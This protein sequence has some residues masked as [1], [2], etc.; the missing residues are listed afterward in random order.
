MTST[1]EINRSIDLM[2]I[3]FGLETSTERKARIDRELSAA[4]VQMLPSPYGVS[5]RI[6]GREAFINKRAFA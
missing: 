5:V 3:A 2:R 1:K 4:R 6:A